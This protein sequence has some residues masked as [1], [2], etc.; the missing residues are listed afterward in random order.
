MELESEI[1]SPRQLLNELRKGYQALT[2]KERKQV[3]GFLSKLSHIAMNTIGELRV[4]RAADF[5]N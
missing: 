3:T 5:E 2:L 4:I 1:V